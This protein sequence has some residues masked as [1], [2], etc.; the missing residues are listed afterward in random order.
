MDGAAPIAKLE[1]NR[2]YVALMDA[3]AR[4]EREWVDRALLFLYPFNYK[5]L[6]RMPRLEAPYHP[7]EALTAV[8]AAY[9]RT[10]EPY[11][12][13]ALVLE[14][15]AE[16]PAA[17]SRGVEFFHRVP[18]GALA[19]GVFEYQ[20]FGRIMRGRQIGDI[21]HRFLSQEISERTIGDKLKEEIGEYRD[22]T[23]HL[24]ERAGVYAALERMEQERPSARS[25]QDQE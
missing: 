18:T 11:T 10:G 16:D 9:V 1:E 5:A 24:M 19:G 20:T 17:S 6:E 22:I 13:L 3:F 14:L 15:D 2:V 25:V 21:A 8:E 23:R 7:Y 4:M 12:V